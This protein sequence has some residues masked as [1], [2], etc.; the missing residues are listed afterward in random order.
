MFVIA[1]GCVSVI[2]SGSIITSM[3]QERK[4]VLQS[5]FFVPLWVF[6]KVFYFALKVTFLSKE[7]VVK[8]CARL[9]WVLVINFLTQFSSC[10]T[11]ILT[12]KGQQ[13]KG[14]TVKLFAKI[15]VRN[16]LKPV[17]VLEIRVKWKIF[18][19]T[20]IWK[21]LDLCFCHYS[22]RDTTN[23]SY[24][25]AFNAVRSLSVIL[26]KHPVVFEVP[27]QGST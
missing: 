11:L 21:V 20:Q 25:L 23:S 3:K 5:P 6:H 7:D 19:I 4:W 24:I 18:Q 12:F 17:K 8:A 1:V 26:L 27:K 13:L 15:R 10:A 2:F 14:S 22:C 16:I 9:K